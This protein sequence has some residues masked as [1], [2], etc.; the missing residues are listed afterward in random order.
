MADNSRINLMWELPVN[1]PQEYVDILGD[2]LGD[3]IARFIAKSNDYPTESYKFLG[4]K[5]QFSDLARKFFKIKKEVWDDAELAGDEDLFEVIDDMI[6]HL[7]ILRYLHDKA[8]RED[9][10]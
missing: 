1:Y 6:G 9:T 7:I 2:A 3:T 8:I 10:L 4:Q 5:G